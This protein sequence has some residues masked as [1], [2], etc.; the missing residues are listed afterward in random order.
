[1]A[2]DLISA[3]RLPATYQA[4]VTA[5]AECS[6]VDEC[7]DWADKAEALAS[8]ARQAKDDQLRKM[9][10]RI[11]ARAV[12]R[13]GELLKQIPPQSG[14][15]TDITPHDGAVTRSGA[16]KQ[17]GLSERQRVTALRVASVDSASFE[18]ATESEDPPTVTEL[19]ELGRFHRDPPPAGEGEVRQAA[20][21][22]NRF[23]QHCSATDPIAL[24]TGSGCLK[25]E[26]LRENVAKIDRW[27]DLY[28]TNLPG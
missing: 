3:A 7:Q 8:Y 12:R 1:M 13:C 14:K 5:L 22:L 21:T 11:Q 28:V 20:T 25:V 26:G 6:K 16:A 10:D 2:T 23:A 18:A 24:A 4:A 17:A 27:L 15:R 9:A 19:A